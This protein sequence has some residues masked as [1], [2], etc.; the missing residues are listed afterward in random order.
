MDIIDNHNKL[1]WMM[2]FTYRSFITTI[3]DF[4]NEGL[5]NLAIVY[6]TRSFITTIKVLIVKV[7]LI[8]LAL[9]VLD[10]L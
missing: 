3:K 9:S 1:M 4:R 10:L 6:S 7:I 8:R 2:I 5:F